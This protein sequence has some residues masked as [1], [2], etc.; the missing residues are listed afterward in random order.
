MNGAESAIEENSIRP[1]ISMKKQPMPKLRSRNTAKRRN[2]SLVVSEKT[3][4]TAVRMRALDLKRDGVNAEDAGMLLTAEFKAKYADW[5]INSLTNFV[6]SIY[7][8]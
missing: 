4:I 1:M 5:P 8:E 3:F 7:A 2:G 6:K